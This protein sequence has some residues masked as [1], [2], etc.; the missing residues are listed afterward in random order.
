V[1]VVFFV[2][3]CVGF[4]G[5]CWVLWGGVL[6]GFNVVGFGCFVFFCWGVVVGVLCVGVVWCFF[7]VVVWF[8]CL[9][10]WVLVVLWG[11]GGPPFQFLAPPSF[12][13]KSS[14]FLSIF[15]FFPH[16]P[17]PRTVFVTWGPAPRGEA[18]GGFFP[19]FF[20]FPPPS[21]QAGKKTRPCLR[22]IFPNEARPPPFCFFF[23][24]FFFFPFFFPE[25]G[26]LTNP[27][28][29][30]PPPFPPLIVP[31]PFFFLQIAPPGPPRDNFFPRGP[32]NFTRGPRVFSKKNHFFFFFRFSAPPL[33]WF[34]FLWF[35]F[36]RRR[37]KFCVTARGTPHP[38][39]EGGWGPPVFQFVS[40]K[41]LFKAPPPTVL[42]F[43]WG[44]KWLVSPRPPVKSP[45]NLAPRPGKF[46]SAPDGL[47]APQKKPPGVRGPGL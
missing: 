33:V 4:V 16:P 9:V 32:P 11:V 38:P 43:F 27:P 42:F 17:N 25:L 46:F 30:P 39:G 28:P 45:Q 6:C 3:V 23:V 19:V 8:V 20:F 5:L 41:P 7:D 26:F 14:F 12:P 37:G 21:P 36:L 44:G 29:F 15:F 34:F 47:P 40:Q 10:C 31:P 13:E 35:F 2:W 1:G 18:P 22:K 24:F